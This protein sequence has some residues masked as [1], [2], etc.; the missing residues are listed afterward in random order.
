MFDQIDIDRAWD[1]A[2]IVDNYDPQLFRKDVC[3]AWIIRNHYGQ[4]NSIY[5][6]EIDHIY[7]QSLGGDNHEDNLRAMQ[8]ENNLSKGDDYPSYKAV[9]QSEG[10][11]NI[12]K[13]VQYVV[14]EDR[15]GILSRLYGIQ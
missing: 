15:R 2:I 11:K 14:N 12:H 3:G 10:N 8:W 6:W 5:G 1:N 7:P 9:V 13:E 4:R